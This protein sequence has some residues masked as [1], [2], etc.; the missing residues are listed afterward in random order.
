MRLCVNQDGERM[1]AETCGTAVHDI[2]LLT[3]IASESY[4]P[5]VSALQKQIKDVLYDRPSKATMDYFLGKTVKIGEVPTTINAKQAKDI[6]RYLLKNDYVD[7]NDNVTDSYRADLANNALA[8]LPPDL[9]PIA[10][11]VHTL[12]QGVFDERVL[13]SMIDNGNKTKIFENELNENFYKKE[14]QMLWGYINHK[15]AYA[16]DFDAAELIQKSI[17]HIDQNLFVSQLQYTVS[18]GEQKSDM[19]ATA[20]ERGDAFEAA[21][22]RTE[23]LRHSEISQVKYDLIGKVAEGTILTRR[24][25]AAILSG[26]SPAKLAMFKYNPEEFINKVIRLIKEQKATMIVEHITYD[27]IQGSYDSDIFTAEKHSQGIDKAFRVH[28]HIQDYVFTD[29]IA[30]QSVE[31][32]FAQ[33]LEAANEVCVYAKLPKGFQI[34]TPVGNYSPDWAIA[35]YAGTVKHIFFVAETKGT[36]ETLQLK[37]IEQAK[38]RCARKLFNEISTE[39]VVYHDV[40]SYQSLLNI[41]ES[42]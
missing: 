38:I 36:M 10:E 27:R 12:I 20:I 4:A 21:K 26:I 37:P 22:T 11:G 19:E 8:P 31:R 39:N 1:D 2:N 14:F 42:L 5:F 23:T 9:Q 18:T 7:D 3:V 35:F 40:D 24:T 17:V 32:R 25:V 28:K 33:D 34:P 30:E 29:G 6:Y 15:Y 16:V 13:D 41:M